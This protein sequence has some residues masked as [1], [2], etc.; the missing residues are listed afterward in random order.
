MSIKGAAKPAGWIK[1]PGARIS[2]TH[3]YHAGKAIGPSI[4][5]AKACCAGKKRLS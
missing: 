2:A 3:T 4:K 5:S 1:N